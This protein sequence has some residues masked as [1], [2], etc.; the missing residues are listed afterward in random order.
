R[1]GFEFSE[2]LLHLLKG[3]VQY[4]L[5]LSAILVSD[6]G[7]SLM[8]DERMLLTNIHDDG[9]GISLDTVVQVS[10][11]IHGSF[12]YR[13]C[14]ADDPTRD[15]CLDITLTVTDSPSGFHEQWTCPLEPQSLQRS[16]RK[17]QKDR[18]FPL[19]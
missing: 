14:C 7:M 6:V 8:D 10:T 5:P 2:M 11:A 9:V 12:S 1:A 3:D 18:R 17:A 13:C 19:R 16:L 4:L 15:P